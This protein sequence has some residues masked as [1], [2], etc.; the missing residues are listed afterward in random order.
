MF[1]LIILKVQYIYI[2]PT[3]T[4]LHDTTRIKC[5]QKQQHVNWI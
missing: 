4:L 3:H 2:T 5:V 1:F